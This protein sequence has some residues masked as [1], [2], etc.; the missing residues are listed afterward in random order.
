MGRK[1]ADLVFSAVVAQAQQNGGL[2]TIEQ[3][4]KIRQAFDAAGSGL[5]AVY[6]D[7]FNA[8][9]SCASDDKKPKFERPKLLRFHVAAR[10]RAA[11]P[12]A[13]IPGV[14]SWTKKQ[15]ELVCRVTSDYV[16]SWSGT[17]VDDGLFQAYFDLSR[18]KG[19]ELHASDL[20]Q[21]PNAQ[22][23]VDEFLSRVSK[24]RDEHPGFA[25]GLMKLINKKLESRSVLDP[26]PGPVFQLQDVDALLD[27][28]LPDPGRSQEDAA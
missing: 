10:A 15:R 12:N 28:L 20:L 6:E 8:C 14:E 7:N 21:D 13:K 4:E 16:G 22:S 19:R 2:V 25:Q 9:M 5:P 3:I 24:H 26:T 17:S 23:I 27:A 11:L 1:I 18:T